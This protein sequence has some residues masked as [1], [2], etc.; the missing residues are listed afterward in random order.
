MFGNM[1]VDIC[2]N[3]FWLC[4]RKATEVSEVGVE[5]EAKKLLMKSVAAAK[6]RLDITKY[7]RCKTYL[8]LHAL[9]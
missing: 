3:V 8:I 9:K 4:I 2:I 7:Y 5:K 1:H 6:H